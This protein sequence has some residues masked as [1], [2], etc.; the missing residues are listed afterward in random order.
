MLDISEVDDRVCIIL[1]LKP[2][3]SGEESK[4]I[5]QNLPLL[6][7]CDQVKFVI[8]TEEDY[9]WSKEKMQLVE[10]TILFSPVADVLSPR[11]LAEWILQDQLKVRFQV[12]LHKILWQNAQGK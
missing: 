11:L 4:N 10:N 2:P 1:D 7:A 8:G 5:W 6:K 9:L 12:Q 3:S